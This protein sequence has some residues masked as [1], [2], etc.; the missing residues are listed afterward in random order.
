M[1]GAVESANK[2]ITVIIKKMAENYKDWSNKL[3]FALWGYRTSIRTSI[4]VTPYSLVF[5]MDAVQPVEL[6]IPSLRIVLESK[7]PE[8]EWV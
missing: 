1:N 5:G 2:N 8:A 3:H 7:L 6:E 4:G